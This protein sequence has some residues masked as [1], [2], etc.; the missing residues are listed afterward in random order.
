MKKRGTQLSCITNDFFS[1]TVYV[2]VT[3]SENNNQQMEVIYA[4]STTKI[5]KDQFKYPLNVYYATGT[6]LLWSSWLM[7]CGGEPPVTSDCYSMGFNDHKWVLSASMNI[8]RTASASVV[9]R[10]PA[11]LID[12]RI[13]MTGN[14]QEFFSQ[15]NCFLKL[16]KISLGLSP[17]FSLQEAGLQM[18]L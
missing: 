13:W 5:C 3:G 17:Q 12:D 1:E 11:H 6:I 4:N 10:H 14:S 9:I 18:L 2:L 16:I 7:I 8:P 15:F